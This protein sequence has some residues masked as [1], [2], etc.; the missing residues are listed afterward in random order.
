LNFLLTAEKIG[1]KLDLKNDLYLNGHSIECRIN[2]EDPTSFAPSPGKIEF[3]VFP[4]GEGIRIDS[5]AYQGWIIPP[6]Y[7]SLIAKVI[8]HALTR[9]EAIR[10]I[11]TALEMTTVVG[12]KTNIPLHLNILS[13]SDFLKGKYNTQF[14]ERLI[15]KKTSR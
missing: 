5:A 12:I 4:G 8:S 2:A 15:S 9:E 11:K 13:N 10:K 6:F 14:L 7:D 3:L 1:E